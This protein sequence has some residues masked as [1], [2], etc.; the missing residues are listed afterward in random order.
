[1][2]KAYDL[3]ALGERLKAKGLDIAEEALAMAVG[4]TMDWVAES[5]V[6]SD[7]PYDDM[8]VVIVPPLKKQ[9]LGLVDK[10]DGEEG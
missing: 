4:E 3:K 7:T 1:M 2:E 6:I 8:A 5:A 10:I 9:V